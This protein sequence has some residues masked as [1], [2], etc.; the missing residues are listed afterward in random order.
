MRRVKDVVTRVGNPVGSQL[1]ELDPVT[2]DR[3]SGREI[4][5]A[6][7]SEAN[8]STRSDAGPWYGSREF[9]SAYISGYVDGE[10]CFTVSISPRAKLLVGWE[11]RPSLSVSQNGDRAEVLHAIQTY[12]GCGS[13]RADSSDRTVKW[14]TRRLEDLLERVI[15]HFE[16]YP[17]LSGK[18]LDFERFVAICKVMATGAHRSTVGLV[19]IVE[20]ARTMNPSGN[21]RY[22]A[23]AILAS[24]RQGEGIVCAP[25]NRGSTRSSDLHEWRNDL[26][27]V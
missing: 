7:S 11:V 10:G 9:L 24:L 8:L 1:F 4:A 12:F 19:R 23:E 14:E 6:A 21:R 15:P 27:A 16:R 20:L 26:G 2:T 5:I 3:P 17:L 13:I 22:E 18:G 25:G